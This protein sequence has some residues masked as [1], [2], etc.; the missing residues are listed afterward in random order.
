MFSELQTRSLVRLTLSYPP[1]LLPSPLRLLQPSLH[2]L[3]APSHPW[4]R[5]PRP[6]LS[7]P[8][9]QPAPRQQRATPP[10]R[11]QALR[12]ESHWNQVKS[13]THKD[14]ANNVFFSTT[15]TFWLYTFIY[16]RQC[17]R[18]NFFFIW[19]PRAEEQPALRTKALECV[20]KNCNINTELLSIQE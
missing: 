4:P 12:G 15:I 14:S 13:E 20:I 5:P 8:K 9:T 3:W 7:R 19:V 11:L 6:R 2:S 18:E 1:P 16:R 10:R 17:R